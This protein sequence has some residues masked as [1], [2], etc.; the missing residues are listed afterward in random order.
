MIQGNFSILDYILQHAPGARPVKQGNK[1][2]INPCPI[3]GHK[4]HFFVYPDNNSYCSFSGCC[5]GGSMVDA[6]MEFEGVPLAEAMQRVHG[7]QQEPERPKLNNQEAE[8][9]AKLLTAKVEGFFDAIIQKYK[10]FS[11]AEAGCKRNNIDYTDPF[12]RWIRRGSR[13]YDR[14]TTDFINASFEKRVQ[15]MRDSPNEYFFKL[16]PEVIHDGQLRS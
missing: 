14:L 12:Y 1:V 2:L 7:D 11:K 9:L 5:K 4:D 13:F 6:L 3:C 16:S 15:M 10:A 8:K